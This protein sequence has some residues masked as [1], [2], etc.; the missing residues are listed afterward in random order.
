LSGVG[1]PPAPGEW[2]EVRTEGDAPPPNSV[3]V[4]EGTVL[5][6]PPEVIAHGFVA[7]IPWTIQAWS[8]APAPGAKWWEA[9]V[10]VGPQMEFHLGAHGFL[11]GGGIHA[12]VPDKHFVTASGHFFGRAPYVISWAGVVTTEVERLEVVLED[13][14]AKE[15]P[16]HDGPAD[17]S[18]FFWFF[19][20]RGIPAEIVA[21]GRGERV[22]ERKTLPEV[23]VIPEQNA[24]TSVNPAGWRADRPPPGWPEE[25][26][27]FAPGEGPRREDDFLLH[28]TPY[29]VFVVPPDAWQGI[30]SL[31]GHGGHGT[32]ASYVPA[33]IE[34]EY[35]DRPGEPTRGMRVVNVDPS[36]EDLLEKEYLP[37]REEGLWWFDVGDDAA[38]IPQLP[39]RFRNLEDEASQ[40]RMHS[41]LGRRYLG[42][43]QLL[44]SG[45]A[46]IYERWQYERYPELVEIRFRLPDVAI[47]LEGWMLSLDELCGFAEQLER[48]ELESGLLRRMTEAA[49]ASV[50]AWETWLRKR[51]PDAWRG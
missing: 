45:M 24:G 11:G 14:R 21:Y 13:G 49:S 48:L 10:A 3:S 34:F 37:H 33:R 39:G 16:L 19:P 44:V 27:E 26:R 23:D 17:I 2:P 4:E 43:G 47:R 36:E 30:V 40:H 18:R 1:E 5:A 35:L 46:T 38:F 8:T 12:R 29:P 32:H 6:N 31:A 22:L 42:Q 9:M 15:I 28:I 25:A 7:G 50:A 41:L 51:Y 20:P